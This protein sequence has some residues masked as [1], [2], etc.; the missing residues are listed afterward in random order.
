M[1]LDLYNGFVP[2]KMD[3]TKKCD[4][5]TY[6]KSDDVNNYLIMLFERYLSL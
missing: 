4:F 6:Y 2:W 5:K 3:F 1:F